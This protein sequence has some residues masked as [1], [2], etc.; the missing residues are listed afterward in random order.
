M[1][2]VGSSKTVEF[3]VALTVALLAVLGAL[4]CIGFLLIEPRLHP[5]GSGTEVTIESLTQS[6]TPSVESVQL[7][8]GCSYNGQQWLDKATCTLRPCDCA[9]SGLEGSVCCCRALDESPIEGIS[10]NGVQIPPTFVNASSCGCSVCDDVSITIRFTI[11][12]SEDIEE[13]IPAAQI[14]KLDDAGSPSLLGISNNIGRFTYEALAGEIN[15]TF[16]VQAV[17]YL[18]NTLSSV[19]LSPRIRF[20]DLTVRLLPLMNIDL[21]PGGSALSLRLG[22]RAVIS[23][24]GSAFHTMEGE[25]YEDLIRF[26]GVVFEDDISGIPSQNFACED[27]EG[28]LQYFGISFAMYLQF[29][30]SAFEQLTSD[31]LKLEVALDGS[32]T[33]SDGLFLVSL[34]EET[35]QW[36]KIIDFRPSEGVQ[37]RQ[38]VVLEGIGIPVE[39]F[40]GLANFLNFECYAEVRTFDAAGAPDFP[41][42]V[43]IESVTSDGTMVRVGTSTGTAQTQINGLQQNAICLPFQ[44]NGTLLRIA[45]M[46]ARVL[47]VPDT[48]M[49]LVPAEFP[50]GTFDITES[51]PLAIGTVFSIDEGIVATV[52]RPRPFY[53]DLTQCIAN[54]QDNLADREDFFQF[55]FLPD[56]PEPT[57]DELC[58]VKINILDCFPN[59]TVRVTSI[60]PGNEFIN[61]NNTD[62]TMVD[63]DFQQMPIFDSS[64]TEPPLPSSCDAT[65]ATRRGAC[66]PYNC[67]S[68]LRVIVSQSPDS[69]RNMSCDITDVSVFLASPLLNQTATERQLLV[70]TQLLITDDYN[71]PN[72]GLYHDQTMPDVARRRCF[73]GSA[74]EEPELIIDTGVAATFT[75]FDPNG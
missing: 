39:R 24:P 11:V 38:G 40:V 2:R 6:C 74:A 71:N 7:P 60:I 41:Y 22:R 75:C 48:S 26:Q 53:G 25:T 4:L 67:S 19:P 52:S 70:A 3:C 36:E 14:I 54:G 73:A 62:L 42:F 20:L 57:I 21:V 37:K 45:E 12:T 51:E 13:V 43:S 33:N 47:F 18:P 65:M 8:N 50:L 64:A 63:E 46:H 23:A 27:D 5:P 59:N 72:L 1:G 34:N 56:I 32:S 28:N 16:K 10:C 31:E 68:I 49:R 69:N 61:D 17:G 15:V 35:G 30:G 55:N 44:C 9:S 29:V 58:Y 66:L